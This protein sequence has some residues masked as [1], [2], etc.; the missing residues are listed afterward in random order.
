MTSSLS[1]GTVVNE[2]FHPLDRSDTESQ[3]PV[4]MVFGTKQRTSTT[5]SACWDYSTS[6]ETQQA[7]TCPISYGSATSAGRNRECCQQKSYYNTLAQEL[8]I[9]HLQVGQQAVLQSAVHAAMFLVAERCIHH[10]I[11]RRP[12]SQTHRWAG[13]VPFHSEYQ[14]HDLRLLHSSCSAVL[15]KWLFI[16]TYQE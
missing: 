1:Q 9:L 10:I 8:Q 6:P 14:R 7:V 15:E 12:N 4:Q 16:H 2:T 11:P 3:R 5:L 13:V